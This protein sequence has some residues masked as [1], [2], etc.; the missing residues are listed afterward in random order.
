MQNIYSGIRNLARSIKAQ[1]L[2]VA[3]KEIRGIYLFRNHLDFSRLQEL[4]LS[5]LYIYDSINKD[6]VTDKISK[7][8]FDSEIY[9]DAYLIWKRGNNKK[10]TKDNKKNDVSLV[11]GKKIN[12]PTKSEVK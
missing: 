9:E 6:I 4:Y 2:F 11:T 7:K 1:N 5:F 10:T 3:A 12:F 8:I